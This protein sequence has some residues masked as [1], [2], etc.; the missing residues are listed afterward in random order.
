MASNSY[1]LTDS[2]MLNEWI[3][4]HDRLCIATKRG[5]SGTPFYHWFTKGRNQFE[6]PLTHALHNELK[7]NVDIA[8]LGGPNMEPLASV[9][10]TDDDQLLVE[11]TINARSLSN[12]YPSF[13]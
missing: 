3:L 10:L 1:T 5:L 11:E 2:K 7:R 4:K 8:W 13:F 9:I 12:H 6:F